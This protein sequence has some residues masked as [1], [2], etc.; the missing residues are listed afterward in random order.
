MTEMPRKDTPDRDLLVTLPGKVTAVS[1]QLPLRM[2]YEEWRI[3][4]FR[5][6]QLGEFSRFA[7]GDALK[8]GHDHYGEKYSQAASETGL[9]ED[10]LQQYEYV[11]TYVHPLTRVRLWSL[12]RAVAKFEPDEQKKWLKKC[13]ENNWTVRELGEALDDAG[14]KQKR[15]KPIESHRFVNDGES[16]NCQACNEPPNHVV[17]EAVNE[18][19]SQ[20]GV[21]CGVCGDHPPVVQVCNSCYGD[22]M[23]LRQ[24]QQRGLPYPRSMA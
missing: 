10:T 5:C 17:H 24:R 8:Y 22:L 4:L 16:L 1:L 6:C 2:E 11:A 9:A 23:A 12:N 20:K 3:V 13:V 15:A 7:I 18:D 14:L 19:V 21:L